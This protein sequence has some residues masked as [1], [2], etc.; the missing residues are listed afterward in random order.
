VARVADV[1]SKSAGLRIAPSSDGPVRAWM[2]RYA[3]TVRAM[4]M[5][6]D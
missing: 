1:I 3:T 2:H 5:P 4:R 6:W